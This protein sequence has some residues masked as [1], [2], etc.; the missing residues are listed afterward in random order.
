M[1]CNKGLKV[2]RVWALVGMLLSANACWFGNTLTE[3]FARA[4]YELSGLVGEV[5]RQLNAALDTHLATPQTILAAVAVFRR[6]N[7]AQRAVVVEAVKHLDANDH[8]AITSA[9][10]LVLGALVSALV[11][12]A[13]GIVNDPAILNLSSDVRAAITALLAAVGVLAVRLGDLL[14]KLPV[15]P[16]PVAPSLRQQVLPVV[17]TRFRLLVPQLDALDRQAAQIQ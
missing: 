17:A 15:S 9:D 4:N 13:G 11:G 7:A 16:S 12:V 3:Q 5:L 6:L 8:L 1:R 10:Q 2:L 14:R